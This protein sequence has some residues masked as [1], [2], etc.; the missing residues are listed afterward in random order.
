[1]WFCQFS[2]Q[3]TEVSG[4]IAGNLK[5]GQFL[6]IPPRINVAAQLWGTLLGAYL[7]WLMMSI[8]IRREH[9]ILLDV[10]LSVAE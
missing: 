7:S 3:V 1:M 8:V 4:T 10:S 5:A 9:D 6:K 2:H